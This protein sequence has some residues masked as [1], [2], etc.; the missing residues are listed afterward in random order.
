MLYIFIFAV[1]VIYTLYKIG[2]IMGLPNRD[3]IV[4]LLC[5]YL[6]TI[7]LVNG[8]SPR[9]AAIIMAFDVIFCLNSEK[10][11]RK[12]TYLYIL[13]ILSCGTV[14]PKIINYPTSAYIRDVS[15]Y[16]AEDYFDYKGAEL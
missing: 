6:T 14:Q 7:L 10:I 12:A 11:A 3:I 1:I 2:K 16:F 15:E 9:W 5:N 13:Y 8:A 4:N